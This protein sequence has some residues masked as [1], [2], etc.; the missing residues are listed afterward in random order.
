MKVEE[1][2]GRIFF[3]RSHMIQGSPMEV[4]TPQEGAPEA[5]YFRGFIP[6]YTPL[7]P[8][9]FIGFAGVITTL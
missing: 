7:Q 5:Y 3:P 1:F 4:G 9:F 2:G 8:W 6:S